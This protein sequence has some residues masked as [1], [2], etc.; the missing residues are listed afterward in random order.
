MGAVEQLRSEASRHRGLMRYAQA[1]VE[2]RLSPLD[3]RH[4]NERHHRYKIVGCLSSLR[5]EVRVRH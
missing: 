2:D 5:D 1:W 4:Q 3:E